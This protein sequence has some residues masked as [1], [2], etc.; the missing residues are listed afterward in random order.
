MTKVQTQSAVNKIDADLNSA[1]LTT[2]SGII[3]TT[4]D[5]LLSMFN[6]SNNFFIDKPTKDKISKISNDLNIKRQDLENNRQTLL[7]E[8]TKLTNEDAVLAWNWIPATNNRRMNIAT[9]LTTIATELVNLWMTI[10]NLSVVANNRIV[11]Y[12]TLVN[13]V[14]EFDIDRNL[15][16]MTT[17]TY[18][19]GVDLMK[20]W[21][22][23]NWYDFYNENWSVVNL[24]NCW[25]DIRL[26]DWTTQN[27]RINWLT[28]SPTWAIDVS[29]I[30]FTD[31]SLVPYTPT[32]WYQFTVHAW[33]I[34]TL[35][36]RNFINSKPLNIIRPNPWALNTQLLRQ[37]V[38]DTYN[39][40]WAGNVIINAMTASHANN[41][42]RLEREAFFRAVAHWDW[43]KF[44][45]LTPQQK[46]DLY[47]NVRNLYTTTPPAWS[48]WLANI[49]DYNLWANWF[50]NR[51]TADAHPSNNPT[52]T[53]NNVAYRNYINSN[54]EDQIINY[55]NHRFDEVFTNNYD[56]NTYLKTEVTNYLT[57]IENNKIDNDT[58]QAVDADIAG[59][60]V[61]K[62]QNRRRFWILWRRDVNYM[63]FFSWSKLDIPQQ[64]VNI[65]TNNHPE[66]LNNPQPVDYK[67]DLEISW[68]NEIRA[69]IKI[70]NDQFSLK[71]WDPTCLVRTI[72]SCQQITHGKV[73]MHIAYNVIKWIIEMAKKKDISL[74]YRNGDHNMIIRMNGK[75][76]IMEE[77]DDNTNFWWTN[78]RITEV[79]FDYQLFENTNQFDNLYDN[80][81]L[82]TWIDYLMDH[83]NYAMNSLHT[84]YR[85]ATE[86]RRLWLRRWQTRMTLPTSFRLSPIKKIMN[87]RTTTNFDFTTNVN[88]NWKNISISFK[89]NKFT[90][91]MDWLKKPISFR[92]LWNL[93]N[94]RKWWVRIFD[95]IER[96]ICEKIYESL[97]NK[98]RENTKISRTSFGVRDCTTGRIYI[99]DEDGKFG[100]VN[101]EYANTHR[102]IIRRWRL[103]GREYWVVPRP[104][105]GR[106]MCS[107]S[108]TKELFKN[109]FIMWRLIKTMNNRMWII[110]S[111][112]TLWD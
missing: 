81:S 78:R 28:I 26:Q 64:T 18:N 43:P 63:R 73:R 1:N 95:G 93:L 79:L 87:F 67:M 44:D 40:A 107:E 7:T 46:E 15:P 91:N 85:Q 56:A 39:N 20:P 12:E 6:P 14:D 69:N 86:R 61:E 101:A 102:D 53:A 10:N 88:S 108:E 77:Q 105:A 104:P 34:R 42:A 32:Q 31:R 35:W 49:N 106:L 112:R 59:T 94:Y 71:A 29:A 100:Y 4:R 47:Q 60:W 33:A 97:I 24:A 68:R 58:H 99:L 45:K 36:G 62:M 9:K 22:T 37:W 54:L 41:I 19:I 2:T 72:L 5:N 57:D 109:P 21:N 38:V 48:A 23:A 75:N 83:F 13:L 30:T 3:N 98:M 80:R 16:N 11:E 111:T 74:S 65:N 90:F 110:S 96:D 17:A 66:D 50:R 89:K 84:Q 92:S 103:S 51:I 76:I 70:W 55:F 52:D 82:R 8:Q 27:V 25:I